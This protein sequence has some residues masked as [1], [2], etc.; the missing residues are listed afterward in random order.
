MRQIRRPKSFPERRSA[1]LSS[2]IGMTFRRGREEG[3]EEGHCSKQSK[4]SGRRPNSC[5]FSMF[6]KPYFL[7]LKP[8][9]LGQGIGR[10]RSL[11]RQCEF[12]FK[13]W[14]EKK[15]EDLM[16]S[17]FLILPNCT[18]R[19]FQILTMKSFRPPHQA[20][21]PAVGKECSCE[22]WAF[23]DSDKNWPEK[24]LA[25][26]NLSFW[27]TFAFQFVSMAEDD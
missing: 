9:K 20:Q 25:I 13:K 5:L 6:L 17:S 19:P 15:L 24:R 23:R 18:W 3:R 2:S 21:T 7:I 1:K 4:L 27:A 16:F 12:C 26:S 14:N 10:I 22:D 8:S 11:W